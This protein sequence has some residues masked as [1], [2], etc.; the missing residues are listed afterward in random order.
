MQIFWCAKNKNAVS[1]EIFLLSVHSLEY[2]GSQNE[3]HHLF[4]VKYLGG[5]W[6]GE[7]IYS[8]EN[9]HFV[10]KVEMWTV[11]SC[12]SALWPQG[13]NSCVWW[14]CP[15]QHGFHAGAQGL[16]LCFIVS[17]RK[18]FWVLGDVPK[19]TGGC[20]FHCSVYVRLEN[21]KQLGN[22]ILKR[23]LLMDVSIPGSQF[24]W[25]QWF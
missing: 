15:P 18:I 11:S 20:T 9:A 23:H 2:W 25:R 5:E 19:H 21:V 4:L 3:K 17:P 22:C 8:L 1:F 12:F 24:I 6:E 16:V 10:W 14:R 7:R 13:I